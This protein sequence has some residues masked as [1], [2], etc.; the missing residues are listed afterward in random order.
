MPSLIFGVA[1]CTI[2][3]RINAITFTLAL[4]G[5]AILYVVG[6]EGRQ[7]KVHM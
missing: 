7:A 4:L 2:L 1:N 3:A 6:Y 5:V